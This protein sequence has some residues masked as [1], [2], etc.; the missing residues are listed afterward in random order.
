M[1][2]TLNAYL[3]DVQA[4]LTRFDASITELEAFDLPRHFRQELLLRYLRALGPEWI[5]PRE[6]ALAAGDDDRAIKTKL[7]LAGACE[8][9]TRVQARQFGSYVS[10]G[11]AYNLSSEAVLGALAFVRYRN[12]CEEHLTLQRQ[13]DELEAK[14][15]RFLGGET[16]LRHYGTRPRLV[17]LAYELGA[18]WATAPRSLDTV[19]DDEEPNDE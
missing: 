4:A 10:A 17:R 15:I 9:R 14:R 8:L 18:Q 16:S 12:C 7:R 13:M 6:P 11:R 19:T 1:T 5:K 3:A 2:D